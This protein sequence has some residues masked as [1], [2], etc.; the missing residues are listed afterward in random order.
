MRKKKYLIV[1]LAV[2]L[3]V[4]ILMVFGENGLLHAF[5]LKRELHRLLVINQSIQ[6]ENMELMEE[7]EYLKNHKGYLELLAHRQGLVREGEIVFQFKGSD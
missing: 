4:T 6:S 3:G 1:L 7:I 5:K 2:V